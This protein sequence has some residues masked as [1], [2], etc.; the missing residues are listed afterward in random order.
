MSQS[1]QELDQLS[2]LLHALPVE[3]MPM[4]IS[5]LDGYVTAVLACPEMVPP[6]EWLPHVWG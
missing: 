6:S 3:T 2:E 5:E 4:T 1:D